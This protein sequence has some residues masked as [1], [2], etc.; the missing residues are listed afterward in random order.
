M[1]QHI[2]LNAL[3]ASMF[4]LYANQPLSTHWKWF[5]NKCCQGEGYRP[6]KMHANFKYWNTNHSNFTLW[7]F[8]LLTFCNGIVNMYSP[9][10]CW[11]FE[12]NGVH[13]LHLRH[14][15]LH[16]EPGYCYVWYHHRSHHPIVSF[17]IYMYKYNTTRRVVLLIILLILGVPC[18]NLN[19]IVILRLP[20]MNMV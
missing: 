11:C 9:S 16:L 18:V 4:L 8:K 19:W 20:K 17:F 7:A 3:I 13:Q 6:G 10:A 1:Y 14:L 5:R 15:T 12:A 2:P